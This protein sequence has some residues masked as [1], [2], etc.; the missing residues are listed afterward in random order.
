MKRISALTLVPVLLLTSCGGTVEVEET[1]ADTVPVQ[2]EAVET[3]RIPALPEELTFDGA[4]FNLLSSYYNDYCKITREEATGEV[5]NDAIYDMEI[6]TEERLGVNIIEDQREYN[7]AI[8]LSESLVAAG[9][10]TY[11]AMNQLDRF[12]IDMMVKGYLR[13][14]E[15]AAHLDL[16]ASW[17]HPDVTEEMSLGGNT[18][19][20]AS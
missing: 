1:A 17:W 16:T 7:E 6:R 15:D 13:P 12:S 4:D 18:F 5:L 8:R 10:D 19:Y 2:T 3:E 20:A 14:L 9:D 11:A